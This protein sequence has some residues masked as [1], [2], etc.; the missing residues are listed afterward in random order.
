MRFVTEYWN[1]V[2]TII[3]LHLHWTNYYYINVI[4]EC[5]LLVT[6]EE[7][8]MLTPYKRNKT[9]ILQLPCIT[10]REINKSQHTH[11]KCDVLSVIVV[12]TPFTICSKYKFYG[13]SWFFLDFTTLLLK[14]TYH[15]TFVVVTESHRLQKV[16]CGT[17]GRSLTCIS[18]N[19]LCSSNDVWDVQTGNLQIVCLFGT[20]RSSSKVR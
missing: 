12:Q 4:N 13:G 14:G 19:F 17:Q 10:L 3:M 18:R 1:T 8:R 11:Y 20:Q 15:N 7:T 5:Y 9:M 6:A 16:L 2:S